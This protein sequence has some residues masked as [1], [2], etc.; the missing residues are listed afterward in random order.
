MMTTAV[1][2]PLM[3]S[4]LVYL[5][6]T[7]LIGR[8]VL[9][10]LSTAIVGDVGDP[11]LNAG[12]LA[13]NAINVPWTAAWYN[14]PGFYPATD[15]LTFSEHL[16]GA[17]PLSTPLYWLTRDAAIAYNLTVLLSYVLCGVAMFAL[18][19]RLTGHATAGFLAGFAYAFAPYRASHLGHVQVLVAFWAPLALL[20]LH[21]FLETGRRRWLA[22]FGIAWMLQGAANGYFLVFFSVFIGFWV[23][24]FVVAQRRWRDLGLIAAAAAVAIVPL[25]PILLRFIEVHGRYMLTRTADVIAAHSADVSA[26]LCAAPGL[27]THQPYGGACVNSEGELFP[28]IAL[29]GLCA[30]AATAA[31]RPLRA[32]SRG[33]WVATALS[34]VLVVTALATLWVATSVALTGPLAGTIARVPVSASN[35]LRPFSQGILLLLLAAATSPA[36]WTAVRRASIPGFYLLMAPV[37]WTF[38]WGPFPLLHGKPALPH[39]P[40][41]WLMLLPGV[42]GLR[43]PAR[44]WMMTVICLCIAT[45]V[46]IAAALPRRRVATTAFVAVVGACG[47]ALDGWAVLPAAPL[48]PSPPRPD[49]MRGGVVLTLPLGSDIALDVAAQL[50][51]VTGGWVSA[52]GYSGYD[53]PHYGR[54]RDASRQADPVV[55]TPFLARADLHVVVAD[56]SQRHIDL[57]ERQPG[58][59]AVGA[60]NGYRQYRIPRQG[61]VPATAPTGDQYKIAALSASCD[62]DKLALA[63]DGDEA[64]R[65]ECGPQREGQAMT[66]DLGAVVSVGQVVPAIGIFSTDYPRWLV[67]ETSTDGTTWEAAWDRGTLAEAVEALV[68]DPRRSRVVISFPSRPARYVRL[69]LASH[70]SV[71]YWTIAELEVWSGTP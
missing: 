64:T 54:L 15:A 3:A 63:L 43:V 26:V 57:V 55:L 10:N 67:V 45:G 48:L 59:T 25:I 22:L 47:L 9:A 69:R 35:V 58:V 62:A 6:V 23:L 40:Y 42:D 49:L 32:R 37:M 60:A 66:A 5:A 11:V 50:D 28:G 8:D 34:T 33:Y 17:S 20:G 4:A 12:I 41:A 21:A 52:N 1:G 65:W 39:G 27:L 14:F 18:I 19:W 38:T 16:L 29:V 44:F 46:L 71:W 7:L 70:D 61:T 2:R 30:A 13:W 56:G 31:W 36:V 68:N 24:W 51:A 53:A